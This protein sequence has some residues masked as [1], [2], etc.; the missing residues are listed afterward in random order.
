MSTHLFLNP[1]KLIIGE[2]PPQ[3]T[4]PFL[5]LSKS[6]TSPRAAADLITQATSNPHTY[7]FAELLQAPQIQVLAQSPDHA[8]YLRLLEIFS[9]GTYQTYINTTTTPPL[10]SLNDAQTLKLR[11]LSLLSL[12]RNPHQLG[13][14]ALLGALSL[15]DARALEDLVISAV[16]ADLLS[17]QL[18][19]RGQSVRVSSV[20]PLRDLAPGSVPSVL[21]QL[22]AWSGRCSDTLSDLEG[23]IAAIQ[24]EAVA[25]HAEKKGREAEM[26]RLVEETSKMGG[27]G[28]ES[29]QGGSN[30][31]G[32]NQQGGVHGRRQGHILNHAL[33]NAQAR[34]G[35]QQQQLQPQHPHQHPQQRYGSKRGSV[36]ANVGDDDDEYDE[37]ND[38]L[39]EID[40]DEFE[41]GV[42]V[43]GEASGG[44][45]GS[46]GGKRTSRRKL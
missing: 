8:S 30:G 1:L 13:Y 40:D 44:A 9:Y 33:A 31:G 41:D 11:Q 27:G 39:M 16:Y 20:S 34:A 38:E 21:A 18:D 5:A 29:Q 6:A 4:Q 35:Q 37:G 45:V 43:G 19:P 42:G 28:S 25:R 17:A 24:A 3:P 12:A 7:V 26:A 23:Q 2:P 32:G 46:R 14:D 36:E 22:Q 15:P 10:P